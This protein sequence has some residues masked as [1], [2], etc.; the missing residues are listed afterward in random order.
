MN[1]AQN[2]CNGILFGIRFFDHGVLY[3]LHTL[4]WN[5]CD[6]QGTNLVRGA[7][8]TS[9]SWPQMPC[10]AVA[11]EAVVGAQPKLSHKGIKRAVV[12]KL[13]TC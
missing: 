6:P 9:E 1:P 12:L 2:A 8:C 10:E 5:E 11:R 3:E 7:L 4:G 13:G